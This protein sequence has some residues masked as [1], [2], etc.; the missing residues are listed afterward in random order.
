MARRSIC[1]VSLTAARAD[2]TAR[3]AALSARR[4]FAC[5]MCA[6]SLLSL[7]GYCPSVTARA[8]SPSVMA[9]ARSARSNPPLQRKACL[10]RCNPG[11][12]E[13]ASPRSA[14]LAMP[15][16]ERAQPIC[17]GASAQP[18]CHGASAQCPKQSPASAE[19]MPEQVQP[20]RAGD[21]FA[22][23][24]SPRNDRGGASAAHLS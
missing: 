1:R 16:G 3:L 2:D 15:R 21:G 11:A 10:S 24:R 4:S 22:A 13:M 8:R 20:G 7:R 5:G 18:I 6:L 19:G 9:R 12:Q 14:R 23:L 17:H